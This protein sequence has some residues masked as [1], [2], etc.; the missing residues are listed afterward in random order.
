VV[1]GVRLKQFIR[2]FTTLWFGLS[3]GLDE[4]GLCALGGFFGGAGVVE[5]EEAGEEFFSC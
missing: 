4:G 5:F 2:S 3:A 1:L